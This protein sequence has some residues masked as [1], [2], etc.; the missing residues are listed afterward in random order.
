M[1]VSIFAHELCVGDI[2]NGK[3]IVAVE[4]PP[5]NPMFWHGQIIF[6]D[7]SMSCPAAMAKMMIERKMELE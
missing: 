1:K 3:L 7:G 6:E 5:R 4:P 2:W